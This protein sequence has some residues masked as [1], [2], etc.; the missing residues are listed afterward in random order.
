MAPVERGRNT[1]T[2]K[3]KQTNKQKTQNRYHSAKET[4]FIHFL[5]LYPYRR[6]LL[7][8]HRLRTSFAQMQVGVL[9]SKGLWQSNLI[10]GFVD[11]RINEVD[12][13]LCR[14]FV[15]CLVA[16]VG[17]LYEV[18]L[19]SSTGFMIVFQWFHSIVGVDVDI[20]YFKSFTPFSFFFVYI[21]YCGPTPYLA[22]LICLMFC[23]IVV[24]C[25]C[26]YPMQKNT[27]VSNF[28][29]INCDF[30]RLN[31]RIFRL[32]LDTFRWRPLLSESR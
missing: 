9:S 12:E 18:V 6:R 25:S 7:V 8:P 10:E 28:L 20:S 27:S 4:M 2:S 5:V 11:Q 16:Q 3:N 32:P 22:G 17:V 14:D 15:F 23:S 26:L 1:K 30:R 21:N 31:W 13:V 24:L 19:Q 29:L